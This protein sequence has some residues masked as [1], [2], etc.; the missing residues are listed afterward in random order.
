MLT[1][2]LLGTGTYEPIML[3][4]HAHGS[5]SDAAFLLYLEGVKNLLIAITIGSG[6]NCAGEL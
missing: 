4:R 2:S 3:L 6:H 5:D 1:F